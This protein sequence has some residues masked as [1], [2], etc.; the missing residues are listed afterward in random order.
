MENA[1]IVQPIDSVV[2]AIEPIAKGGL[3]RYPG[4]KEPI[5]VNQDIQIY[6]KVAITALK[7]GEDVIRYGEKIGVATADI[8]VGD[9][10]HTHNLASVRA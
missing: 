1:V 8:A 4:C 6:H 7:T 3:V 10:V 9:H 5:V 2:A